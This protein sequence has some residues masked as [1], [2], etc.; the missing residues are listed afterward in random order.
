MATQA[1]SELA[2]PQ[3]TV[4]HDTLRQGLPNLKADV[5]AVHPV[6]VIQSQARV[7]FNIHEINI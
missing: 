6:E 3:L 1:A 7:H 5:L 2:L 4:P